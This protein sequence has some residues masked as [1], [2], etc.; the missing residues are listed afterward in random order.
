MVFQASLICCFDSQSWWIRLRE[1]CNEGMQVFVDCAGHPFQIPALF[2][3]WD[4][5]D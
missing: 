4:P 3:R 1:L 2:V 5:Q